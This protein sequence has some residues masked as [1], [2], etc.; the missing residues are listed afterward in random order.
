MTF[1]SYA[2]NFEDVLLW[3]ALRGVENGFYIDV[4]AAHPDID[5]VTRAF[6][7]RG[8]SGINVEPTAEFSLRLAAARPRDINLQIVL[9]ERPGRAELFVVDG[10]G[11]S[12]TDPAAVDRIRKAG[13][14]MRRAEVAVDTLTSVCRDHARG[15]IHFLKI[16]VEGAER[17]VLAGADFSSFRPWIVLV[18]ATAPMSTVA[19]H[20]AWESILVE[21]NYRFVW[22]DGLNRFYVA[23]ERYDVLAHAFGTPVNVFD[24]FVRAADTEWARRIQAAENDASGRVM[25]L[26][27][28]AIAAEVRSEYEA[29][30][31]ARARVKAD[32]MSRDAEQLRAA[33]RDENMQRLAAEAQATALARRAEAAELDA[34]GQATHAKAETLRALYEQQRSAINEQLQREATAAYNALRQST[35]W[36]ITAPLRRLRSRRGA[37]GPEIT[38][39]TL[40]EPPEKLAPPLADIAVPAT[41]EGLSR[42]RGP[43]R[44]R[45][46]IHQYHAGSASGDAITNSMLLTRQ[47]LRDLGYESEIFVSFREP[48]LAHELRLAEDLPRHEHYILIVRH[49]MG[50]DAFDAVASIPAPK[51]LLYHN[52]TPPDLLQGDASL[53]RHA[54]LGREQLKQWRPL[55]CSSL[56][57]SEYNAIE[58]RALGFYPVQVCNTLFDADALLAR[59]AATPKLKDPDRFTILFVGRVVRS[60]G[61]TELLDVFAAFRNRYRRPCRLV[62]AGRH[63][64][65]QD[66][67]LAAVEARIK[68]YRIADDVVLTGPVSD[69]E[70]HGYYA[71][72]DV[73][74]SMSRHEGFGVPLIEAMAHDLPVLALPVA[75]VPYTLSGTGGLLVDDTIDGIVDRLL[76]LAEQEE[77]QVALVARQRVALERVRW[78]R[79][80]DMLLL[81]LSA[82]GAAPPGVTGTKNV[83]SLMTITVAGHVNGS[84]SLAVINRTLARALNVARPGDVRLAPVEGGATV[85]L[86]G[87]PLGELA[88][89]EALV[90]RPKPVTAPH[91]IISQHYPVYVPT[92]P[93]D[94]K[95]A[96]FFWEES[97]IP[98]D[99]IN[100][101]NANFGGVLAPTVFVAKTLIDSGLAIPVRVVGFA[102]R[103][104]AYEALDAARRAAVARPFTFLHVSSGFPRKGVDVLLAAY[105]RAFRSSDQVHLI[106]K[107]FPNP[108][109]TVAHQIKAWQAAHRD[110]PAVTLIDQDIADKEMLSLYRQADAVVL[111]TRGEGFNIPAA[112]AIAARLPLIVTGYSGHLDFCDEAVRLLAFNFAPSG[113]HFAASG[114]LWVEPDVD[115]LTTALGDAVSGGVL[116][117]KPTRLLDARSYAEGVIKA[118]AD[119]LVLAP[120]PPLR[121]GWVS[122]WGV[123]CGVAEY[124]RHLLE[125][126]LATGEA[127][128]ITVLC[129]QRTPGKARESIDVIV[130]SCWELGLPSGAPPL[131]R[132][133]AQADPDILVI[134]H[135]PGLIGWNALAELLDSASLTSRPVVVALHSTQRILDVPSEDRGKVIAAL[136]DVAR[137]VVH[138]IHDVNRLKALGVLANVVMIPQGALAL[139]EPPRHFAA[140]AKD[141]PVVIGCYGFFFKDKG[142]FQL[143]EAVARLRDRHGQVRLRL[144]NAQYDGGESAAEIDRCRAAA[145]AAGLG[146][147]VEWHTEFM[148]DQ[149]SRELLSHCDLIALPYQ[150][151]KEGSSAALR[152]AMTAGVPVAVTP[153]PLF[154]EAESAVYRFRGTESADI[155]DGIAFLLD[156]PDQQQAIQAEMREW[157]ASRHWPLV[158]KR[159]QG[160]LTGL[161]VNWKARHA[162]S[163]SAPVGTNSAVLVPADTMV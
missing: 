84:Y 109:N 135:Q 3:R 20:D 81:A 150:V 90:A 27:E 50:F 71:S 86:S 52:I 126:M 18:E 107:V 4:G 160:M 85:D 117:S 124:S 39:L 106:I 115:D 91:V 64:G 12:T 133:V 33:L 138:T 9:G 67:Y 36:R 98:L 66:A 72:A 93:G 45:T 58:L 141:R 156:R 96:Y 78:D 94:L 32:E 34:V 14:E 57:D 147:T 7:D 122:S 131:A 116:R 59:A 129:D 48:A 5:S 24:D 87:V 146:D 112:E 143:I 47:R 76:Q 21:A 119:L 140:S 41:R 65:P 163:S 149:E 62:L 100:V 130:R 51:I 134:Q 43:V 23:A 40:P 49:S 152:M 154:D 120:A 16:D 82:A 103:L 145:A 53:Q 104:E 95:L 121:I 158:A 69:D 35:S 61:Q 127:G 38:Q 25:T 54:V 123:R 144:V 30:G 142:I 74:L 1:V 151:S 157:L 17:A 46:T 153:L 28:R 102:P 83:L 26:L 80:Q 2:Q 101:L 37:A 136:A 63:G 89:V 10:T 79:H 137:I 31:A 15:T 97:L 114:S 155:A 29:L 105:A 55:V 22:F 110:A 128:E 111:P 44:P 99:T 113:S 88:E 118:A 19:T 125:A 42:R 56:A 11:L 73:Y 132:A 77:H 60:K 162:G 108:H 8:W 75:A 70:L 159:F 161:R 148:P 6:Y 13:M 68:E 139:S 92:E